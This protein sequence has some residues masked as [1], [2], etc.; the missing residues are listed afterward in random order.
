MPPGGREERDRMLAVLKRADPVFAGEVAR[1]SDMAAE[2]LSGLRSLPR[3]PIHGDFSPWNVR[4]TGGKLTGLFDFDLCH[5][6]ILAADLAFA[7]RGYHDAV[8]EGYLQRRALSDAEI[9]AL[10]VLWLATGLDYLWRHLAKGEPP[11]GV[12]D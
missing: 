5:L 3:R 9:E 11:P 1:I 10:H 7:R 8:V 6:D 4:F 12:L 2:R